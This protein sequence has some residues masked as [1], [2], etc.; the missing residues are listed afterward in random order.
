MEQ[1][2]GLDARAVVAI[3][4]ANAQRLFAKRLGA[5]PA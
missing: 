3:E 5:A 2:V 1:R 4:Y